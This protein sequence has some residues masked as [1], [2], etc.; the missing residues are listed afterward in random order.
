MWSNVLGPQQEDKRMVRRLAKF[1]ALLAAPGTSLHCCCSSATL[2]STGAVFGSK[3]LYSKGPAR[4]PEAAFPILGQGRVTN[5]DVHVIFSSTSAGSED[6][7]ARHHSCGCGCD[8]I[9]ICLRLRSRVRVGALWNFSFLLACMFWRRASKPLD[10][11]LR[12]GI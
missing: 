1:D 8:G 12:T 11:P 6:G 2:C 7:S 10:A 5:A 4:A 9:C 3:P